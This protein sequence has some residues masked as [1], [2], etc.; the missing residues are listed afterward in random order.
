MKNS[1][2]P[3]KKSSFKHMTLSDLQ[4]NPNNP[5]I[6]KEGK[7]QKL[8]RS[9]KEFPEMLEA[10]PIVVNPDL[11]VLGGNMRLKACREAGLTT[12]PVYVASWEEAKENQF[13]VKDNVGY[14]EWDWDILANEWDAIELESWGLD[15]PL[16]TETEK[17]SK[18]EFEDVYYTP[19]ESPTLRLEDCLQLDKFNAKVK[20]IDESPLSEEQKQVMRWFAYRF[21]RIDFES[22]A[23]YYFFNATEDEK[24]VIERLRLVLCDSGLQGFIADDLLHIHDLVQGW[25]DD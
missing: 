3:S 25:G 15:L 18:I 24:K 19:K 7:F 9:I 10:R 11:V 21:I 5:R 1:E 23:N 22:V 6:I 14:G 2:Q 4:E 12:V 20:A 13:I 16:M 17:L 8:V